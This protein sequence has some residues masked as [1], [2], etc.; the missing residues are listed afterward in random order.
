LEDVAQ[1]GWDRNTGTN[2]ETQSV[3][4]AWSVIR[5][6]TE[7]HHPGAGEWCE[8]EG[9]E[10]IRFGG[11]HRTP[12]SLSGDEGLEFLPVGLGELR[13]Q[14]RIPVGRRHRTSLP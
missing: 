12:L 4:L 13:A 3:S 11:I 9:R 5:V 7:D 1:R 14:H 8:V 6:L 2:R 10:D